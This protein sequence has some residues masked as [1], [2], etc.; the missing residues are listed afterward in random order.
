[1]LRNLVIVWGF[2]FVIAYASFWIRT[3]DAREAER[4]YISP[5]TAFLLDDAIWVDASMSS[6]TKLDIPGR[7]VFPA[8][9][10]TYD[11]VIA[12]MLAR[13]GAVIVFCDAGCNASITLAKQWASTTQSDKVFAIRGGTVEIRKFV[14]KLNTYKPQQ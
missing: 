3:A 4:L 2:A 8:T 11:S 6:L 5:D 9:Q 7:R 12:P 1:M 13:G 14:D 10:T